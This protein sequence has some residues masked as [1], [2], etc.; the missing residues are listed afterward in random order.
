M[1]RKFPAAQAVG[2]LAAEQAVMGAAQATQ[3][4]L[5]KAKPVEQAVQVVAPEQAAQLVKVVGQA[6][7]T[8]LTK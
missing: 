1:S 5:T 7:Q 3:A 2:T 6:V 8:P 4:P